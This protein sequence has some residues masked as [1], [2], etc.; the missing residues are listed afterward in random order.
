MCSRF[1]INDT[2]EEVSL[3]FDIANGPDFAPMPEVRP[4]NRV[5]VIAAGR[6][7]SLL[8]WGLEVAWDSKPLINA[9]AETITQKKTF[10][11]L[12]A[13]RCLVPATAY[14]EWRRDTGRKIKTRIQ[15]K[16]GGLFA[17]AGLTDGDNFTIITC[18]PAP[19]ITHIHSRMPVIVNPGIE[20][21]WLNSKLDFSD[22]ADALKPVADEI[23]D[24]RDAEAPPRQSD[25]FG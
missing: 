21:H 5:P 22:V 9:R 16:S 6:N 18:A 11:P 23:L 8:R 25:L 7:I 20:S 15:L 12:L 4:T 24:W 13:N 2:F 14:F 3:R 10:Q 17:M 19:A 1:E